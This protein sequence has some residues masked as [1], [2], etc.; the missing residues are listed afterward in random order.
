MKRSERRLT[1]AD[2]PEQLR[3]IA[4]SFAQIASCVSQ[5]ASTAKL[6]AV[7]E[8]TQQLCE[9][10]TA[11]PSSDEVKTLLPNLQTALET[12]QE[13]WPRLGQQG[14]FRQAVVREATLW[15]RRLEALSRQDQ[16][17]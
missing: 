9:R 8:E 5:R 10:G 1:P 12:W 7:L 17:P 3:R 15:S 14:E 2:G 13:V 11:G 16:A 4:S 6:T